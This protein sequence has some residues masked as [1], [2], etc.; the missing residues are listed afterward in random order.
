MKQWP[1]AM[2]NGTTTRS[3]GR[4]VVT[5]S[6]TASTTPIGSWPRMSP[7]RMNG[8]ITSYKCRSDPHS[9]LLVMRMIASVGS[10]MVGSGTVSTRTSRGP[11]QVSARMLVPLLLVIRSAVA[12][13]HR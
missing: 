11:C 9:P 8:A 10:S 1:Q 2:L 5:A 12:H 3:P 4:R 6:P 7:S 13:H